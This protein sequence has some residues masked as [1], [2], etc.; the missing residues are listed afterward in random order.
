MNGCITSTAMH[1]GGRHATHLSWSRAA[2]CAVRC[3]S[4]RRRSSSAAT[5]AAA[6]SASSNCAPQTCCGDEQPEYCH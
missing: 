1:A 6:C 2:F 4:D 5:T 3:T